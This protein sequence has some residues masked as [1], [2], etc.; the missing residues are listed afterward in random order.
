MK[1]ADQESL[2]REKKT[3]TKIQTV[4]SMQVMVAFETCQ[5][6]KP[7]DLFFRILNILA[8]YN[9]PFGV[10]TLCLNYFSNQTITRTALANSKCS[11]MRRI[12]LNAECQVSPNFLN[13][14]L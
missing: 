11:L 12:F 4:D 8:S 10:E 5:F 9:V 6:Q 14:F 2:H 3:T 13:L 7:T 1:K